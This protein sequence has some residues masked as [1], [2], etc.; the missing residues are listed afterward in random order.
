[1]KS[2][3]NILNILLTFLLIFA[4]SS[5]KNNKETY[6]N[7]ITKEVNTIKGELSGKTVIL[8]TN[9]VHGA[10]LGYSYLPSI[11]TDFENKGATV[12]LVD[13][14]DFTN[15]SIYTSIS[16]GQSAITLMN[17]VGYD[18]ISLGN[19]EFDFGMDNLLSNLISESNKFK[20]VCS[21]VYKG[22]N[23]LFD[24]DYIIKIGDLNI[25]FFGL[26][27][28][29][30]QTKVSPANIKGLKFDENEE[31][32]KTTQNE[33]DELKQYSDIIICLSHLGVDLESKENR[34]TVVYND[35]NGLDFMIDAHSH[36]VMT[37]GENKEKIQ[38]TGTEFANVGAIV[39]DN[40]S[41]KIIDNYLIDTKN[42]EQDSIILATAQNIIETIDY[43]YGEKFSETTFDLIGT[44]EI[45]RS[46]ETNL[47]DLICD[48]MLWTA[49]NNTEL[50]VTKENV[51]AII[52]SGGIRANINTGDISRATVNTV[53]PFKNTIVIKY[54]T[55]DALIEALEA[56]TYCSPLAIGGFPQIAGMKIQIDT[57]KEFDQGDEYPDST[58]FSPKSIN[59]VSIIDINGKPFDVNATYAIVTNDFCAIGGDTY[60]AFSS[61]N[62]EKA[63]FDTSIL[64]DECV[65]D[66][67]MFA[68]GEK[69]DDKYKESQGRIVILK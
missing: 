57:T 62:F 4:I 39:I 42:I 60:Y 23:T 12:I 64:I 29:E 61:P 30:T 21:D 10:I 54:I 41:K 28:P 46:S 52:N 24:K 38:S 17:Q 37:E 40:E 58:Y 48:A 25:A 68:L 66:Y 18:I 50:K 51:I 45:V 19:H 43:E 65:T 13:A 1:M 11:K 6:S 67:I 14:G 35:V 56:S 27:T 44:K 59:R 2:F 31:L 8:H 53:L 26:L 16:K 69:I 3:K 22:D 5:C 33:I 47:G 15:G 9:D 55:G 34:S 7:Y 20:V 63:S 49:T 36:T 32:Y